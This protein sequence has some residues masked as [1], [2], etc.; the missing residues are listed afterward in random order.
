MLT[1][2]SASERCHLNDQ[3]DHHAKLDLL[4]K[5]ISIGQ[6][7]DVGAGIKDFIRLAHERCRCTIEKG[8]LM[9]ANT[10]FI[11]L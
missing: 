8:K 10:K 9:K 4:A 5:Q 1:P 7:A 6:L 2:S 3:S 11:L